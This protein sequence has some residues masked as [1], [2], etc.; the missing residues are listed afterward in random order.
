MNQHGL[1]FRHQRPETQR[2]EE[3]QLKTKDI[4]ALLTTGQDMVPPT[5]LNS[6][7]CIIMSSITVNFFI[8]FLNEK[9]MVRSHGNRCSARQYY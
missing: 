9:S 6:Y 8:E 1:H 3:L 5:P 7:K 2:G 4:V